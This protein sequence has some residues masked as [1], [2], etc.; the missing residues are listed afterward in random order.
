MDTQCKHIQRTVTCS[1]VRVGV[2]AVNKD[3]FLTTPYVP[4]G[5]SS[6][7]HI[8]LICSTTVKDR[9]CYYHFVDEE[10]G[11]ESFG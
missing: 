2:G 5:A 6:L 4:V 9:Y 7:A 8:F 1:K 3:C 10:I 11:L